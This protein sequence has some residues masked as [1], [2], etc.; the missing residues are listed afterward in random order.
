M[1][2]RMALPALQPWEALALYQGAPI[3]LCFTSAEVARRVRVLALITRT[4]Y[5]AAALTVGVVFGAAAQLHS[6][7]PLPA[8]YLVT[9]T[10]TPQ[11]STIILQA[12]LMVNSLLCLFWPCLNWWVA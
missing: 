10:I 1:M 11:V 12:S 6:L 4:S 5:G 7:C 3:M 9:W 2:T 8:F